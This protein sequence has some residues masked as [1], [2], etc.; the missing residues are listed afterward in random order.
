MNKLKKVLKAI[1]AIIKKPALLNLVF[2]DDQ[3]WEE[4][5]KKDHKIN[6]VLPVV[7]ISNFLTNGTE[8]LETFAFLGGGS[9]PTDL[10]LLKSISKKFDNCQYFEIGTWRGESVAN[11]A[12]TGADCYTLNLSEA[13]L[14]AMNIPD[15]YAKL[16]GFFSHN[17]EQVHYLY[18][19]SLDF[20][21][22]ALDK[23]FDLIFIDGD[24]HYDF[25]KNDTQKVFEHLIH[26]KSIVVWHD[27]AYSPE[28]IRPEVL[29]GILDGIPK[30]FQKNLYHVSNTMCAIFTR[31]NLETRSFT[32]PVTPDK[33][34]RV[35]ISIDSV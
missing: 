20:D 4:R 30:A 16:H 12:D 6:P 22:A 31:Q 21:F 18:G 35:D 2:Y 24:H 14:K 3:A 27:Y 7:D 5:I 13:E 25:V 32:S 28:K 15:A 29:A 33:K 11:V 23:K 9:L 19:N 26:D 10:A 34:F 8:T 17:K 1:K